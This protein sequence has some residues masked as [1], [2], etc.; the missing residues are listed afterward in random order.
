MNKQ[1]AIL[2]FLTIAFIGLFSIGAFAVPPANDNFAN[3]LE[4]NAI[5][6]PFNANITG[7]NSEATA[8]PGEP[9]HNGSPA[10]SSVWYKWTSPAN[11]RRMTVNLRRS[12]INTRLVIYIGNALNNLVL[13]AQN[14]DVAPGIFQ[15]CVDFLPQPNTTYHFAIDATAN[16]QFPTFWGTIGLDLYPST[17]RQSMDYDSDGVSDIAVYRPSNGTWYILGSAQKNLI[18]QKW[19]SSG[20]VPVA[21]SYSLFGDSDFTVYR[22][23]N[24]TWYISDKFGSQTFLTF[25]QSGDIPVHGNFIGNFLSDLAVFRPSNGTWYFQ[26]SNSPYIYDAMQFGI[27]GDVP[28]AGDYDLDNKTDIAVFRPS[29]GNWYIKSSVNGL[30]VI[31][32]GVNGDIPVR[33]D[34]DGDGIND[35]T[36]FRPSNGTWYIRQSY[37]NSNL[38]RQWGIN[39]DKP[40]SGDF[41]GDGKFDFA[42]YRPSN[43]TWYIRYNNQSTGTFI[44]KWGTSGDFP[45]LGD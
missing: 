32:W 8:E 9:N 14:N 45:I 3:A 33:A 2:S 22:P 19:G 38:I 44:L 6:L 36:V 39:G 26:T 16:E 18:A 41:D 5:G 43:N 4:I 23:S 30:Q 10:D 27:T 25:G 40:V 29:D 42:V 21:G 28:V 20:D 15:S 1:N 7:S 37:T 35:P 12:D 17:S 24:G 13:V 34:F 31:H 11:P